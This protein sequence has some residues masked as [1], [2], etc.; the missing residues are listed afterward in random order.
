MDEF[1]R[2]LRR[3]E[4][5]IL[6]PKERHR[7]FI[8]DYRS[9][10]TQKPKQSVKH[11]VNEV[12]IARENCKFIMDGED[13]EESLSWEQR[14]AKK[15]YDKLFKEYCL[16]EL[17]L[18]KEGKIALRFR[19]QE[20]VFNGKG[21]F[22]CGSLK[23]NETKDLSS[24][25][26]HFAYIEDDQKKEALVKVRLCPGCSYKLNYKKQKRKAGSDTSTVPEN[27]RALKH[28]TTKSEVAQEESTSKE[29]P[30]MSEQEEMDK[31]FEGLFE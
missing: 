14:I 25:E 11:L 10:T 15:Y 28:R 2:A 1:N 7:K 13:N 4:V 20:E 29:Q 3:K 31:F 9:I 24:W 16:A 17:K 18:Y 22:T 19:T 21:Q 26:V 8:T 23:C 5:T 30:A 6:D 27:D 12:D